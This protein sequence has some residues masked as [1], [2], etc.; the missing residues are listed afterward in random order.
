M[1]IGPR[2]LKTRELACWAVLEWHTLLG[3]PLKRIVLRR[4]WR[5]GDAE[6][7][8]EVVVI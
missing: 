5:A 8:P 7:P 2:Q 3:C 4:Q 1:G 6:E